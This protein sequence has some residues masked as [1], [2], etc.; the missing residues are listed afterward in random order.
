MNIGSHS[1][2]EFEYSGEV[3]NAY[4]IFIEGIEQS[5]AMVHSHHSMLAFFSGT[6]ESELLTNCKH[7]NYYISLIVSF[8]KEYKCKIAFPSKTTTTSVSYIRN[9]D[10][11]LVKVARK[12]E[13]D[14]ILVGDLDIELEDAIIEYPWLVERAKALKKA[15]EAV[16]Y[17]PQGMPYQR[18][19]NFGEFGNDLDDNWPERYPVNSPTHKIVTASQ[20]LSALIMIDSNKTNIVVSQAIKS[21]Q[22]DIIDIDLYEDSL[23]NNIEIIHDNLYGSNEN[24]TKHCLEALLELTDISDKEVI[25]SRVCESIRDTLYDH[26]VC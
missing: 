25:E 8:D 7:Y 3:M 17:V 10:G 18:S 26:A 19:F 6:D 12:K 23:A 15:K 24:F 13:I 5:T 16:V 22:K 1:Y 20:F 2:T 14:I 4:D 11:Q 21:V 9:K